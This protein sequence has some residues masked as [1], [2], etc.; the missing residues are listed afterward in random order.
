MSIQKNKINKKIYIKAGIFSNI[1]KH[2]NLVFKNQNLR[3]FS[4]DFVYLNSKISNKIKDSYQISFMNRKKLKLLFGFHRTSLLN[5]FL[6]KEFLKN[7]I[8]QYSLKENEF[9]SLLERRLDVLLFRLGFAKT[10]FEAKHLIA[11][12]KIFI[13]GTVI[14]SYTKKLQKG[15]IISFAPSAKTLILKRLLEEL[16]IRDFFFNT[17]DNLE[18]NYKTLKIIVLNEKINFSKQIQ[19]Y[20]FLLNWKTILNG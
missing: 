7:K 8:S 20:S 16:K 19:H 9:C 6:K 5:K 12:K 18:I 3:F 1:K 15:D 11:H 2:K 10:L 13:N 17:F 14:S 4:P